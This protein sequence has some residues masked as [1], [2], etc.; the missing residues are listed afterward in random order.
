[1]SE[2]AIIASLAAAGGD[3]LTD[4]QRCSLL[5]GDDPFH[6]DDCPV[7][8]KLR[9]CW[10][11][12]Y[13]LT[14][15]LPI[16]QLDP[17]CN[18]F[19]TVRAKRK[20]MLEPA[21]EE[22]IAKGFVTGDGLAESWKN[23]TV[24]VNP[25]YSSI[26]PWARKADEAKAFIFLVNNCTTPKW[27]RELVHNGGNYKFEFDKRIKFEPP[28]RIKQSSNSRDQVLICNREGWKMIGN[29]LDGYG[30]WWVEHVGYVSE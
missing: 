30:R 1:M 25:P 19:S 23:K 7:G 22:L 11:T 4:E 14:K 9:D 27:Y 29:A 10:C 12:P 26:M 17:C 20:V 28:P 3:V 16:V 24:F 21:T 13:W 15:L 2:S 18:P 8:A 5:C 6:H